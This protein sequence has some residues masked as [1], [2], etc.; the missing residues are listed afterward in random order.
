VAGSRKE[1][2][3]AMT[4]EAEETEPGRSQHKA[5]TLK[6]DPTSIAYV[7]IYRPF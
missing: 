6:L 2:N 4:V 1:E 7:A 5:E 3:R